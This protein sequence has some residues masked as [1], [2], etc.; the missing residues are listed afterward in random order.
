MLNLFLFFLFIVISLTEN[1]NSKSNGNISAGAL[2]P[3][4][5]YMQDLQ[6]T[7]GNIEKHMHIS[8]NIMDNSTDVS[9]TCGKHS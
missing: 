8:G 6:I 2:V 3:A 4:L 9:H 5:V 7:C 1:V